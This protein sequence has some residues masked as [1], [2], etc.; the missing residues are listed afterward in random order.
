M[1][2]NLR[3]TLLQGIAVSVP[4][5]WSRPKVEAIVVP[6]HA[7]A[8]PGCAADPGCY[9]DLKADGP[10]SFQWPGGPGV[11]EVV[12]WEGV[13]CGPTS[14]NPRTVI[15]ADS[16]AA[17]AALCGDVV[18][19]IPTDPPLS[20]G[21]SFWYC[22][23]GG[24]SKPTNC[25]LYGTPVLMADGSTAPVE[26]LQVGQLVATRLGA[27]VGATIVTAVRRAHLRDSWYTINGVLRITD[28]HPVRVLRA[29]GDEWVRVDGLREGDAIRSVGGVVGVRSLI[30]HDSLEATVYVE[31]GSGEFIVIGDGRAYVVRSR[32]GQGVDD[33]AGRLPAFAAR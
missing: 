18:R 1:K 2:N 19:Q 28:D 10:A 17:A 16:A 12:V 31:T 14:I 9:L 25:L 30:H 21:C 26:S 32:Y 22:G 29:A 15:V 5:A 23:E 33:Q 7:A 8:T 4:V 11:A 24:L 13:V 27:E 3:R 20:D 6:A